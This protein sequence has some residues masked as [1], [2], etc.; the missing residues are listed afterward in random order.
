[1]NQLAANPDLAFDRIELDWAEAQ[2]PACVGVGAAGPSQDRANSGIEF[3][4]GKGL[5][6]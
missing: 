5:R 1:M 3:G 6:Q 2:T 4:R